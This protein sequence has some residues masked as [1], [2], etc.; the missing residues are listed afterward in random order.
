ML[1]FERDKGLGTA[2]ERVAMIRFLEDLTKRYRF[3]SVLEGPTD[4]ISGIRGL[5]SIPLARTGTSVEVVLAEDEEADLARRIWG[6]LGLSERATIRASRDR[7]LDVEPRSFDL[8]WNFNSIPRG[9]EP[10]RLVEDMCAASARYVMIFTMNPWNYGVPIHRL[11]HR[12]TGQPWAHGDPELM[13]V[14]RLV[15][16]LSSHGFG[17]VD[18]FLL[19]VPWWPDIDSPIEQVASD[20]IPFIKGGGKATSKRLERFTYGENDLPYFDEAKLAALESEL[21]RHGFIE[22]ATGLPLRILFAHH[23]GILAERI[24]TGGAAG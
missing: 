23:R 7:R 21:A 24:T 16:M 13:R 17:V 15:G 18:R 5:N 22:R 3:A 19:D 9:T 12:A 1:E 6:A 2:Y 10:D 4:E 8:V 20:L 14:R 11:H